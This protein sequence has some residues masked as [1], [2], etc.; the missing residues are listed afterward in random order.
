MYSAFQI[1][2]F[3]RNAFQVMGGGT[4]PVT[5]RGGIDERDYHR[6]RKHL[7]SLERATRERDER[8]YIKEVVQVAK[9]LARLD[10]DTPEIEKLAEAPSKTLKLK[11]IDFDA[12]SSDI[13]TLKEYLMLFKAYRDEILQEQD[14]E[15]AFLL[16]IQ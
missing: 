16:L 3:Q 1:N 9:D 15:V 7:E 2:S 13:Q 11:T 12:L 8:K 14:D 6:Y 10:I 5:S 4:A